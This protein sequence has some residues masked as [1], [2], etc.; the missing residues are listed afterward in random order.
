MSQSETEKSP[1]AVGF[2]MDDLLSALKSVAEPTRLRVLALL[3]E[4]ELTVTELTQILRQSQP[5]VSR[6]LKLLCEAGVLN[7]Y[8]EG[9]WVFYRL[10][11]GDG[12]GL[13]ARGLLNYLPGDDHVLAADQERLSQVR[14]SRTAAAAE[15]F[16]RVAADWDRLRSLHVADTEVEAR[17][18]DILGAR[19][20]G[21]VL[22]VGTGTGRILELLAA[23]ADHAT[24]IDLSRE[25]LAVARS[26]IERLGLD[27]CQVRLG[28]M[29]DMPMPDSSADLVIFH[30]V[31][32]YADDPLAAILETGRV[33]RPGGRVMVIDFAPHEF[34]ELR[35]AHAHRRLG[36]HD[37]EVATWFRAAAL[38]PG[39]VERLTGLSTELTVTIWSAEKTPV[40]KEHAA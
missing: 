13:L 18:L 23:R 38:E 15:Y 6:H 8:R 12:I 29:Y 31:L 4:G 32:H 34:E 28:D 7:R 36:F 2:T 39:R 21:D 26:N 33:L 11:P 22:D 37:A 30:Q 40:I 10:S 17:L 5:R 14:Q 27:N 3:A 24:G 1:E 9:T 20:Y 16:G 25:M 35:E 19:R